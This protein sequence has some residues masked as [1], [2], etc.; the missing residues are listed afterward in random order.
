VTR[1]R[2]SHL[3]KTMVE[4]QRYFETTIGGNPTPTVDEGAL[5]VDSTETTLAEPPELTISYRPTKAPNP[6]LVLLR[7]NWVKVVAVVVLVPLTGW[8]LVQL[9]TL[10]RELGELHTQ[11]E[12]IAKDQAQFKGDLERFEDQVRQE[13]N[14]IN[15]RLDRAHQGH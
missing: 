14:R 3:Q 4:R 11:V 8:V 2:R 5:E 9:Y 6:H 12:G 13:T 15:D 1:E 10:N 7:E